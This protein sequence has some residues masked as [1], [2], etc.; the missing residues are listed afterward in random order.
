MS[1]AKELKELIAKPEIIVAPGCYDG[2]SA[3]LV[4]ATGFKT[5]YMTGFG[6][7][8]S[9]LGKPDY[10]LLNMTEMVTHGRNLAGSL[11]IPLIAD[12]DTGYGNPLNVMRTVQEYEKAGVAAIHIED[13]VFPKRC[14]HMEGKVVIPMKEHVKKIQA[15][16]DAR[17]EMLIIARTDSRA[18]L[19]FEEAIERSIAYH[20]AGADIVF[21]DAPQS[22]KELQTIPEKVKAPLFVNM[23]EG[24][25]TP[26][27]SAQ[28][29]QELGYKIVIF[30]CV[31][32]FAAFKAMKTVLLEL[33]RTGTSKNA[34]DLLEPFEEYNK[35]LGLPELMKLEKKYVLD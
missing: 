32:V 23:T 31:T 13:Q 5:A 24:G 34:L 15:A 1:K 21:I 29:L 25:K 17:K 35:S 33:H 26:L 14:G 22:L 28:E 27:L 16:V 6:S 2:V 7:S 4:E 3:R 30:P 12:A 8:A 10:G 11:G 9:I 20:E 18:P 19:G